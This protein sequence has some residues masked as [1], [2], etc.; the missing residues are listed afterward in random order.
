ML[1]R[2]A[3]DSDV[4]FSSQLRVVSRSVQFFEPLGD[5]LVLS[6]VRLFRPS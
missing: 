2:R 3:L 6:P 4:Q 1:N 5:R